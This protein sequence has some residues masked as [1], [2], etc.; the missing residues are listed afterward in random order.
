MSRTDARSN[1][2]G[3]A[4]LLVLWV[5]VLLTGLV[6]VFAVTARTESL[7]GRY[8]ARSTAARYLAEA[9]IEVAAVRLSS[10]DPTRLWMPD[11]RPYVFELD[12]A[13]VEVRVRDE[14]GRIDL[15]AAAPELLA[16]LVV[17]VGGD[18][19]KAASIGAA[20]QDFRDGDNL[21]SVGGGA[22]DG[23]YAAAD[24]PYGAKDRAFESVTELQQVLGIDHELYRKLAPH[25]TI[26]TG[27][28]RPEAVYADAPVLQA[29]G[30]GPL[31]VQAIMAGREP[32]APGAPVVPLAA[33]GTGTYSI[34][35][36]ATRLD[37]T[38]A[39]VHATVRLGATSGLGLLYTPLAWRVGDPD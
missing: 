21:L 9:G 33:S 13:Q 38:R 23:E 16:A 18:P 29:L 26:N 36:R 10:S 6:A 17:A 20:I 28:A 30:L 4:L 1:H 7:Q 3:A 15:N 32:V 27:L 12:G 25:V 14:S 31:Q 24:L 37:G 5:L 39:V 22:E 2:R 34:S 8:L 11:G 35:S 19:V